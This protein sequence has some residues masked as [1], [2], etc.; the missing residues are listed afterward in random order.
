MVFLSY[1]ELVFCVI[2]ALI[3]LGGYTGYRVSDVV[4]FRST[5]FGGA[6]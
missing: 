4:R 1:P 2:G 3:W 6:A 5:S